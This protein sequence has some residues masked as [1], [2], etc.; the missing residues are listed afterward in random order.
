MTQLAKMEMMIS[1]LGF[2]SND[3]KYMNNKYMNVCVKYNEISQ[4]LCMIK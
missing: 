2:W 1:G 3:M 4:W